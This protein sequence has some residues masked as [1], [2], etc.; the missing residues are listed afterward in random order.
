MDLPRAG[1]VVIA[2]PGLRRQGQ[3]ADHRR[4]AV[5]VFSRNRILGKWSALDASEY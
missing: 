1:G 4:A 3:A 2:S 5:Q